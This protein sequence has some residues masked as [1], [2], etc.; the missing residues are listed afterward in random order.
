MKINSLSFMQFNIFSG[1]ILFLSLSGLFIIAFLAKNE[2]RENLLLVTPAELGSPYINVNRIEEFL[3]SEFLVTYEIPGFERVSLAYADIPVMVIGTNNC[4]SQ[5]LKL[6]LTEGSFF[7]KQAWTGRQRHA[8]LNEKAAF[9]IFG[10][11]HIAGNQFRIRNDTWIVTGVINDSDDENSR[12]YVPSSIAGGQ[13]NNFLAL[14]SSSAGSDETLIIN[15]MKAL[16]I[17]EINFNFF[18]LG[19][20]INLLFERAWIIIL[21]L[22]GFLFLF[23]FLYFFTELKKSFSIIKNELNNHYI[24]EI[25]KKKRKIVFKAV[26]SAMLLLLSPVISLFI[27]LQSV[28]VILPWQKINFL[29]DSKEYFY[30]HIVNIYNFELISRIIFI[31]SLVLLAVFLI[32]LFLRFKQRKEI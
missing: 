20:H 6:G 3:E 23:L 7:S 10:S 12:I 26:L 8:V 4:Y 19:T 13:V 1:V 18:N 30:P 16:G 32:L 2:N 25:L 22:A 31:F 21:F 24:S 5:I 11:N 29:T 17:H 14:I 27:F 28:S 9:E 15:S